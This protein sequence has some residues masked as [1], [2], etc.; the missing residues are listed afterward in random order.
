[1]YSRQPL[2]SL[3]LFVG[4]PTNHLDQLVQRPQVE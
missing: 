1:V 2:R 3:G 4:L